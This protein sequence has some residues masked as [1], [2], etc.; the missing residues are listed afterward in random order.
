MNINDIDI[1]DMDPRKF[2]S[3][4]TVNKADLQQYTRDGSWTLVGT[5]TETRVSAVPSDAN[6]SHCGHHPNS[7]GQA[8]NYSESFHHRNRRNDRGNSNQLP[9]PPAPP[10]FKVEEQFF[11]L[12]RTTD[13]VVKEALKGRDKACKEKRTAEFSL[14]KKEKE[15]EEALRDLTAQRT[16]ADRLDALSR[17]ESK[18]KRTHETKSRKMERHLGA[19][20][21]AVGTT[22]F[23]RIVGELDD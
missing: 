2:G 3:L 22:E 19:L 20:R 8:H 15:L 16:R 11:L 6:C 13:A 4:I 21:K 9:D 23:D 7:G 5:F 10:T 14:Q 12:A 17:K 18:E 1:K